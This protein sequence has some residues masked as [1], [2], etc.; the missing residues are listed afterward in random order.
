MGNAPSAEP[1]QGE[2]L[3]AVL[4][5]WCPHCRH[6]KPVLQQAA[7]QSPVPFRLLELDTADR[8]TL[9][10]LKFGGS[11]PFVALVRYGPNGLISQA[12]PF[13]GDRTVAGLLAFV[14]A[15]QLGAATLGNGM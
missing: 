3:V 2:A 12:V 5:G 13:R 4:A 6:F 14:N 7:G 10:R 1:G 8:S 15:H 9:G 11:V